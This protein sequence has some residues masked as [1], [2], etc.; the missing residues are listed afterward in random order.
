MKK[1]CS[2][3]LVLSMLL[4]LIC[5]ASAASPEAVKAANAL[6]SLGLFQGVGTNQ[7]GTPNYDLDRTPNRMEAVTMLVRLLGKEDEAKAGTWNT[8]FTDVAG[9]AK[10]YVGYAYKNALTN[11]ISSNKFGGTDIVTASQYITF[12]LRALGYDGSTDFKWDAAWELSDKVGITN[13]QYNANTPFTRGDV[14][15]ISNN[16]LSAKQKGSNRTLSQLI[17]ISKD[18]TYL[19]LSDFESIKLE[20]PHA[21]GQIGYVTSYIDVNGHTIVLTNIF[22]KIIKN[23]S[24]LT[25]HDMTTGQT[26]KDA[27]SHFDTMIDRAY[28]A[29]KL[30]YMDMKIAMLTHISDAMQGKEGTVIERDRLNK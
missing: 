25:Y 19:A 8:P 5:T 24:R 2:M 22:Y 27:R 29:K 23:Y 26:I 7:D 28:G 10:P 16:A 15:I 30:N 1:L 21:E 20:Y 18:Y 17:S 6:H 3:L 4:S 13:G 14:A 11:G 9:W 12:V